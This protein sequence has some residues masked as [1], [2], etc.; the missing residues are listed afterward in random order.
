L[1]LMSILIALFAIPT[2]AA[3]DPNASRGL[4]KM[5]LWFAVFAVAYYL[6][7]GWGHPRYFVPHR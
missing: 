1:L 5:A 4:K 7:I 6:W 3:R 2:L